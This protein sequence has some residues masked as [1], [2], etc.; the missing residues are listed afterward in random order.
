[1]IGLFHYKKLTCDEGSSN[2][3]FFEKRSLI[4][5]LKR[6]NEPPTFERCLFFTT[7]KFVSSLKAKECLSLSYSPFCR[8]S[9]YSDPSSSSYS[10]YTNEGVKVKQPLAKSDIPLVWPAFGHLGGSPELI[11]TENAAN[12]DKITPCDISYP[13]DS[14]PPKQFNCR[15]RG[16]SR[17]YPPYINDLFYQED[18][19]H[20][21]AATLQQIATGAISVIQEA[22]F[23]FSRTNNENRE[24]HVIGNIRGS[25][26]LSLTF[27]VSSQDTQYSLS[28]GRRC[29]LHGVQLMVWGYAW[30]DRRG[31]RLYYGPVT[32]SF[33]W[34]LFYWKDESRLCT[35]DEKGQI[36]KKFA[37]AFCSK[38][39]YLQ[40]QVNNLLKLVLDKLKNV[41]DLALKT[42]HYT[43]KLPSNI[44]THRP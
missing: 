9:F 7:Q 43:Y 16:Y 1:M 10:I 27:R 14:S 32:C 11:V 44:M 33:D 29:F 36:E 38:G 31:V 5:K 8:M 25:D 15:V 42:S 12:T 13:D 18:V 19:S 37:E 30:Q 40:K 28:V 26:G 24:V 20:Y 6:L 17:L 34:S 3:L 35:K 22:G 2:D 39:G 41:N 4:I 21:T 23:S